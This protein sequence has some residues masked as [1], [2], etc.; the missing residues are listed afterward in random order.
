M[1]W[2]FSVIEKHLKHKRETDSDYFQSFIA[3]KTFGFEEITRKL[4]I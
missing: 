2:Y 1:R 4:N 3:D